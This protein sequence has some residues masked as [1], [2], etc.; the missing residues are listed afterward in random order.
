VKSNDYNQA[1]QNA[2]AQLEYQE[3]RQINLDLL[4]KFG[5][6][7]WIINNDILEQKTKIVQDKIDTIDQ[8][9]LEVNMKRKQ[10]QMFAKK[11][12]DSM[13]AKQHDLINRIVQ[14]RMANA[15]LELELKV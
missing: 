9:L 10:E 14:V 15:K 7:A 2:K 1:V 12:L 13:K 3:N 5:S 6:N 8:E 11:R 4:S